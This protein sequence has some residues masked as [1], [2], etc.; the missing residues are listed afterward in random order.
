MAARVRITNIQLWIVSAAV[1]SSLTLGLVYWITRSDYDGGRR[2]R[3]QIKFVS[4]DEMAAKLA[5]ANRAAEPESAAAVKASSSSLNMMPF[6]G[7]KSLASATD[8]AAQRA[9]VMRALVNWKKACRAGAGV[10]DAAI[11]LLS[12]PSLFEAFVNDKY[13]AKLFLARIKE[14][15]LYNDPQSLVNYISHSKEM[16]TLTATYSVQTAAADSRMAAII[17]SSLLV[18]TAV[19]IPSMQGLAYDP[20]LFASLVRKNVGLV[21]L[22]TNPTLVATMRDNKDTSVFADLAANAAIFASTPGQDKP[23]TAPSAKAPKPQPQARKKLV[24]FKMH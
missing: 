6:Y 2:E 13:V 23:E 3:A 7:K 9:A 5:A 8:D 19:K 10:T 4:N 12:A 22:L 1:I 14:A 18:R 20:D 11:R 15:Q 24:P 17:C 21:S 16:A